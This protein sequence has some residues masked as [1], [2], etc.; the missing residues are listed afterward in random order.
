MKQDLQFADIRTSSIHC[1]LQYGV[2][3]AQPSSRDTPQFLQYHFRKLPVSLPLAVG[4][5]PGTL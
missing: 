2:M 4:Q 1:A 3:R 5:G